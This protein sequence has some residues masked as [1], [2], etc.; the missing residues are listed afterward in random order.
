MP[1]AP[2]PVWN[3]Q[4]ASIRAGVSSNGSAAASITA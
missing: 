2:T 1:S 4:K 3:A